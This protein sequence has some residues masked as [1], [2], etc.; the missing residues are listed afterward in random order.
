MVKRKL[1]ISTVKDEKAQTLSLQFAECPLPDL[2]PVV[3]T[4]ANTPR[5]ARRNAVMGRDQW[6]KIASQA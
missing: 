2:G 4:S 3:G 5:R 6:E 1:H